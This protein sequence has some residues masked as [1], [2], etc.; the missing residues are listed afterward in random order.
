MKFNSILRTSL[1]V[2]MFGIIAISMGIAQT[3]V[4][5]VRGLVQDPGG[6]VIANANVTLTN[7]G[8]GVSRST[9]TN[10]QGEYVFTQLE[11]ATYSIS[12]EAQGFKKLQRPG[13]IV[14]T[15]ETVSVDVRMEIGQISESVQVT[16][17]V[18]LIEN[19]NAS[20]G[21]VLDSQKMTD[22]PNL[23][24]NP[25]LLSTLSAGVIANGDPRFNRFE[26]QSGESQISVAG[27]PIRGN[28]Y[29][30]DGISIASS[31]NL[32]VIIPS[33]EAVQEMN[34]QANTYDAS[35]GRTGGGVFNTIL[36]TGT[37]TFHG[38]AFGY[39]RDTAWSAN[40]FIRN[41]T[42]SPRLQN[43][44]KNWGGGVGG[45]VIIPKIYNG[46]NKTFFYAST[47]S[48][49]QHSS[50]SDKY[51]VPTALERAGNYSQSTVTIYN[52]L[53]TRPCTSADNC[54]A[55]VGSIRNPFPGNVIPANQVN[56]VG[57][58]ITNIAFPLP[59][60]SGSTD[61]FNYTGSSGLYDRGYEYIFKA[62]HNVTNWFRLSASFMR[63]GSFEPGGNTLGTPPASSTAAGGSFLLHRDVDATGVNATM[64]PN[65]TT[66]VTVRYGFNRFPARSIPDSAGFNLTGLGLPPAYTS[67]IQQD[68]FPYINM[69]N[70]F[71]SPT[72]PSQTVSWSKNANGSVSKFIGRH[73]IT[74]GLDY[75]LIHADGISWTDAAGHFTFNGVFSREFPQTGNGTG[76]DFADLLMGYP[77][78]GQVQTSTHLYDF[79][80][81]YGGYLQDDIR[82]SN[83]LTVNAGIRYEYQTGVMEKNN[84][85][86]VGFNRT[87]INP[88]AAGVTGVVP[89]GVLEFAG[90]NGYPTQCCNLSK[91]QFG[92]RI[93]MAYQLNTKTTLR[94]GYGIFYAPFVFAATSAL[95]PGYSQITTYVASNNGNQTPANSLNNP[96][97][98]GILQ[99]AG[100]TL[101]AFTGIGS[102]ISV[103]DQNQSSGI[104]HQ[105]SAD[106]QRELGYGIALQVGYVGSR[107]S[108]L[109][110]TPT[111]TSA[112]FINQ[113]P[114]QYLSMGSALNAS[115]ANP[116][117]GHPGAA[118]VIGNAT[119][120]QAQL[121]LPFP[122]Y[123]TI[124]A[125][126]N[127]ASAQY[128]SM[129]IKVQKRFTRG[130]TFLST[131]TW[132]KNMDSEFG[133]GGGS[134]FNTFS[135]STPPSQ[136]Q[137]FYSLGAEWALASTDIPL[138]WTGSWTY[139]LPFGKGKPFLSGSK[140]LDYAVGGWSIN[141]IAIIQNGAP[142]FVFQQNLNSVIGTGEQRPNATGISPNTHLSP[143]QGVT[144]SY[145]NP[146]A[147]S[148]APAF[149]FGNVSRDIP[150]YGPGQA[151]W[152]LSLFKD[153]RVK[154]RFTAQFRAEALNAFNTPLFANPNTQFIPGSQ[155][156]GKITYQ[157]NYP[158]EIQL[159]LRFYF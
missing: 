44:W 90:Q 133:T 1:F 151:N 23:G 130:L 136:P 146:A 62:E 104:V 99:P 71:I 134:S 13:V 3:F 36:K 128:D 17:E 35:M 7:E 39:L 105:F 56:P 110:P 4:G 86:A 9:V 2:A 121:L 89:Y 154:E 11:P 72:S 32:A 156:F 40:T 37:N 16:T 30:I 57:S 143:E 84:A 132:S 111:G 103:Y 96:F 33:L 63:Y 79:V 115:V 50:E 149:T 46:R 107:S 119:V 42:G 64:T 8:T 20:N 127:T 117:Y 92:P 41:S 10:A 67:T 60:T 135:G 145:I 123:G 147:F 28:N 142:L 102:G 95:A 69:V 129:I 81:Y 101:G 126:T 148:Q 66:V 94:A 112:L 82:V 24:R 48:Y 80:R 6:A 150:Y 21:Q 118:G 125:I 113:V 116:F 55:G 88:I 158:R 45:P 12:V 22:L 54:P 70:D 85:L 14:G 51:A 131:F 26:D 138:R 144:Q 49:R 25:F 98:N 58:A 68:Y 31:T 152:D 29:L 106:L 124:Q 5:G 139:Q 73:S 141:G 74:L 76:A 122:E 77:S 83:K 87:Q 109:L 19:A 97:P 114:T 137:N 91:T 15:Q 59:Q 27:G 75:R 61:S 155:T 78:S 38:D 159:G 43:D 108:H 100:N 53:S 18:P 34:L 157:A 65:P 52:P 140:V 93:G 120:A 153:F 47:E